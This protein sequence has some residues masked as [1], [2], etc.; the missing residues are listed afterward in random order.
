M[1]V[2]PDFNLFYC[3]LLVKIKY[4]IKKESGGGVERVFFLQDK[5]NE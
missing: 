3:G 4:N 5:K 2:H 1:F